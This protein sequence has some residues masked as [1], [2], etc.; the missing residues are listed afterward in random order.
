LDEIRA[1]HQR[2]HELGCH[3][4]SHLD[5]SRVT[6]PQIVDDLRRNADAFA[7]SPTGS[8][9]AILPIPMAATCWRARDCSRRYSTPAAAPAA[10][11]ITAPSIS[12]ICAHCD[13]CA[14][15]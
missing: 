11:A 6:A 15:I 1:L 14:A 12:A 4:Y 10:A 3:T 2:G 7:A 9:Q 13:L 8:L 5:C